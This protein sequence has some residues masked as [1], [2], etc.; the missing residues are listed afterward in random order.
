MTIS[1]QYYSTGLRD[2]LQSFALH[3][4]EPVLHMWKTFL[5]RQEQ[6]ELTLQNIHH[7]YTHALASCL[8]KLQSGT[9][10]QFKF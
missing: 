3:D 5:R 8:F 7:K 10:K 2:L 1:I 4:N 6:L 9:L